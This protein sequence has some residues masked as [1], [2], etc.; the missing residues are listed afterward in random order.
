M[1]RYINLKIHKSCIHL[2]WYFCVWL[3]GYL[4]DNFQQERSSAKNMRRQAV[5]SFLNIWSAVSAKRWDYT[6]VSVVTT[7]TPI[8][9][10]LGHFRVK[11]K[12]HYILLP[13][14][15]KLVL[16]LL[17]TRFIFMLLLFTVFNFR[18]SYAKTTVILPHW[19]FCPYP[20]DF[21]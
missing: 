6:M 4:E 11:V 2:R 1:P 13:Y 5:H 8:P 18:L 16:V 19:T 9:D 12:K 17:F 20:K 14:S 21:I 7:P 3:T 10:Q 15:G